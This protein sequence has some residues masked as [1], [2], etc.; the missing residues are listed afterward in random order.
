MV[1]KLALD[2]FAGILVAAGPVL[3]IVFCM[4]F[5]EDRHDHPIYKRCQRKARESELHGEMP[6]RG[7]ASAAIALHTEEDLE[8]S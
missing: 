4:S 5:K 8:Q 3:F 1:S 7:L 2:V 6:Q